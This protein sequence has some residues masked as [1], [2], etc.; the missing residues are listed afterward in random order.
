MAA[1]CSEGCALSPKPSFCCLEPV[2]I[3][4][5]TFCLAC[6]ACLAQRGGSFLV[7]TQHLH[8]GSLSLQVSSCFSFHPDFCST[9]SE[10]SPGGACSVRECTLSC[11]CFT[12]DACSA[13]GQSAHTLTGAHAPVHSAQTSGVDCTTP[14]CGRPRMPAAGDR[15]HALCLRVDSQVSRTMLCA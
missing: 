9:S 5:K 4:P 1:A 6:P 11:S 3:L 13:A 10:R 8:R 7:P 2:P 15:D 12:R 14:G